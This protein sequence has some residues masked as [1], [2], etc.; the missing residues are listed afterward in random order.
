MN[1]EGELARIARQPLGSLVSEEDVKNKVVLPILKA[2]GYSDSDFNYERRTGRGYVDIVVED[3][4]VGIVV[5]AKAPRTRLENYVSQLEAYVFHKHSRDRATIAI[6]TDGTVFHIYAVT[7]PLWRGSLPHHRLET[8]RLAELVE[9]ALVAKVSG[10]L[11]KQRNQAGHIVEVITERRKELANM[12]ERLEAIEAEMA[13]L[14]AERQRIDGRLRE[15]DSERLSLIGTSVA[16]VPSTAPIDPS[17]TNVPA[18]H[19]ILRLLTQRRANSKTSAVER[20]WLD[21]QLVGKVQGIRTQQA[22]S[23]GLIELKKAGKVDYDK[24]AGTIRHVWLT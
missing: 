22:V 11:S 19:H 1:I 21:A 14:G 20:S 18:C 9:P 16:Y 7:E 12:R 4:P 8:F 15:L 24:R 13:A 6:L 23:F 10:L 2:L 3:F 17:T 5:E